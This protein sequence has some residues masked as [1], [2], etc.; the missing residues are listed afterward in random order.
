MKSMKE[1]ISVI[2]VVL[3][4]LCSLSSVAF[5]SGTG[6]ADNIISFGRLKIEIMNHTVD[7]NGEEVSVTTEEEKLTGNKVSRIVKIKNVCRHPMYVRVKIE[8][9]GEDNQGKFPA[10]EYVS[11][12]D[13]SGEWLKQDG[14]YYYRERLEPEQETGNLLEELYFDLDRLMTDHAGRKIDFS[15]SAQAVQS[16]NNGMTAETAGGWPQEAE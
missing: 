16:E 6:T 12:E 10:E 3:I 15:V 11:F 4:L 13:P 7:E 8:F 9:K 14:W 5:S 1:R 2:C